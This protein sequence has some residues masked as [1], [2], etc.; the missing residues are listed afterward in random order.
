MKRKSLKDFDRA[1]FVFKHR[2]HAVRALASIKRGI[3]GRP[4]VVMLQDDGGTLHLEDWLTEFVVLFRT[5]WNLPAD[6]VFH[7]LSDRTKKQRFV[8]VVG[9][10]LPAFDGE[11]LSESD[12]EA[13]A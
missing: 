5:A 2:V 12:R 8:Q 10:G 7:V 6:T 3:A 9:R 1:A 13:A 11:L 4:P